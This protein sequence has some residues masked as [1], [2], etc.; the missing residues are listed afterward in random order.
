MNGAGESQGWPHRLIPV[1]IDLSMLAGIIF[2]VPWL[3]ARLFARSA[4]NHILLVP[5]FLL[6]PA[7]IISIRCLPNHSPGDSKGPPLPSIFL[8]F[9]QMIAYILCYAYGTNIGGSE[10]DND[11]V[12][13]ILFF[14]FL[15]LV[16]GAVYWPTSRAVPGTGK[17]LAAGS[18]G[19]IS[20]NYLTLIGAAVWEYYCS[21]PTGE[22]P[23]YATGISFLV[24]YAI[25]YVLFLAF[26][27]LPRLYLLRSTGDRLGLTLYL[28]GLAIFLWDKVPPVN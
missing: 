28:L 22:N 8:V 10:S 7:G 4:V 9:F 26:F 13:V 15:P 19:L 20:V 14:V 23:V 25:L 18:I 21:L 5:G 2:L 17:A 27:G 12:A 3:G 24:L 16:I 11:G 1:L 6:I